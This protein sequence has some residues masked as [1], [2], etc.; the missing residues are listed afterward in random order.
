MLFIGIDANFRPK[1]LDISTNQCDPGVNHGYV[2]IVEDTKFRSYLEE[3]QNKIPQEISTCNNYDALKLANSHRGKGLASSDAGTVECSR[4]DMK[5]PVAVNDLQKGE[6]YN[7][8]LLFRLGH[9]T[10]YYLKLL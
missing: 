10:D 5:R 9:S 3:Y 6:R 4:H 7:I 8:L 1:W 2:Y